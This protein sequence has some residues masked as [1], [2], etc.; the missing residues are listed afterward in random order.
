RSRNGSTGSAIMAQLLAAANT[1]KT[2]LILRAPLRKPG[3]PSTAP[4]NPEP[5][6]PLSVHDFQPALEKQRPTARRG[7]AKPSTRVASFTNSEIGTSS[8]RHVHKKGS[9]AGVVRAL[10][11]ELQ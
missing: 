9:L 5:E 7:K 8:L 3:G 6:E 2:Q 1:P 4:S 10:M 11:I